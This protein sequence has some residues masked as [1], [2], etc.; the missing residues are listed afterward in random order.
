MIRARPRPTLQAGA[1]VIEYALLITVVSI[2]L[3]VNLLSLRPPICQLINNVGQMLGSPPADAGCLGA[4]APIADGGG[5]NSGNNGNNGNGN[6]T[7]NGQGNN[8]IGGG[9]GGGSSNGG[10]GG[11]GGGS[12]GGGGGAGG[13]GGKK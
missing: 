4:G 3:A 1:M 11:G 13:G 5:G 10:G 2:A 12:N 7:G 6:G 9:T 8:G